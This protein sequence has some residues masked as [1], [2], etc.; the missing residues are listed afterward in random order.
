MANNR[1]QALRTSVS[2][3]LP[4]TTNPANSSYIGPG[5]FAVNL[6]DQKVV[7]S[8]GSL[9]FE[10][11]S[12]LSTL[13]VV[14]IAANGTTGGV[15]KALFSNATGGVYW[16]APSESAVVTVRE[17]FT[18]TGSC[19]T[20]TVTGGYTNNELDVFVN[21]VKFINGTEVDVSDGTTIVFTTA[22]FDTDVIEVVGS[23]GL[24]ILGVEAE[25]AGLDTYVQFN[26]GGTLMG[27]TSGFTF[28][29]GTNTVAIGNTLS[30]ASKFTA[31]GSVVNVGTLSLYANDGLGSAGQAL[32]S[33]GSA[34]YWDDVVAGAQPGGLDTYVQFN[35]GGSTLNGTAGFVFSKTTNNVT[36]TN[37]LFV[38][39]LIQIGTGTSTVNASNFSGTA[40]NTLFVGSTT[41]ENVVSNAQLSANLA[42]YATTG[43]L[44]AYQTEA[45]LAD[46]VATLAANNTAFVGSVS[47]ANVVSNAQLSANLGNYQTSAGMATNVAT[48]TANNT[49][50]VGSVS[51]ANVVSNA[52]LSANLANYATTT[53][54]DAYQTEAG[55]ADNVAT[56]SANNTAYV[57]SVTAANVVSNA[58][59]SANLGNYQTTA[60]LATNVATL[61]ANN[62]SFVGSVSAANVVSNAQLSANLGNY[63]TTAGL[64]TNVATLTANNTSF[65]GSESAANVVS[66]AQLS[67]NLAN[68]ATTTALD[69]YQTEAGLA[70]NVAT[71][72][73]NNTAFVG[74]VS[75]ANVVSNAQLSANL[76]NYQTTAGLATN[77]ATLTANNANNLGTVAAS[78]YVV[79]TDSRTLSGNL[80]F[81]GANVNFTGANVNFSGANANYSNLNVVSN[82]GVAAKLTVNSTIVDVGNLGFMAN[83]SV[84]SDGNVLKSNGSSAYWS[85]GGG[86]TPG[87]ANTYVQFND[88]TAFNGVAG[89][90]FDKATNNVVIANNLTVTTITANGS[91]G[92]TGKVM[93]S[94]STGGLFWQLIA[95]VRQQFSGTGACTTFTVTDGYSPN[96]LD[97][98]V[99]G[100]KY[101][102]GSDVDVSGGS[103]IIF[104]TAP[105]AGAT[106][107]VVGSK[108]TTAVGGQPGGVDTEVQFNDGG[109]Q[110]NASAGFT[111]NKTTNTVSIGNTL[112]IASV[113]TVNSTVI[114]TGALGLIANGEMG[115]AGKALLSNSIGGMY[116]G[117]AGAEAGGAATQ[118]QF[119]D[120][121]TPAVLNAT[122]GFTFTKGTN[123][124]FVAN[125]INVGTAT[126]NSTF[127]SQ[128]AN[129]ADYIGG[130][131]SANVV[132]N[133]QLS[134]NLGNYQTSAGMA[135]NVATLTA[136]ETSF[137]G[138]VSAANVVSN[139]QLSAN[140]GN[141]QTTTGLAANV[142]TLA[143]NS[144][145]YIGTL[146]A[147]NVVSNAQLSGN[148]AGYV[149]NDMNGDMTGNVRFTGANITFSGANLTFTGANAGF[150]NVVIVSNLGVA[151]K[152]TVNSTVVNVGNLG[153]I[154]NGTVGTDLQVLTSNGSAAYWGAA[155]AQGPAGPTGPKGTS[156]LAPLSSETYTLFWTNAAITLAEIRSVI[157]GSSTPWANVS[158][159]FGSDRTS[160]TTIQAAMNVSSTTTGNTQTSFACGAIAASSFVWMT[161]NTIGGTLNEFHAT[162]RF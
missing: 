42:G 1:Y 115:S 150:S 119:N 52:Q 106:I 158:F 62:T 152:L 144:A 36:I 34:T 142:Q 32:F 11:G 28:T 29:K 149:A 78:N 10:I 114:N 131:P 138:G 98:F 105:L 7:S 143:A 81:S 107:E 44:D 65:V 159:Y 101:V 33:N 75:A 53:S 92:T 70:D 128:T 91:L 122:A 8:D 12:N 126:I 61:T 93:F 104:S 127:F 68:Y 110:L 14:S 125:T 31:N 26:D 18:G 21:G 27:G 80:V 156:V 118:V 23:K 67:A 129:N 83:G 25:A 162:L 37:T 9:P 82:L 120:G 94:N 35:D 17:Q 24:T 73:A 99:N 116:W 157:V 160:A 38:A 153:I 4:N 51:A 108:T 140:L 46:N 148:L 109:T 63:Q 59:L 90:T 141:Y 136:N 30:V 112:V 89:F 137:V 22:P 147:A 100:V 49:S 2:G 84:G 88:S 54:L 154:A 39:N 15:G 71:L 133:A 86:G 64:A 121:G 19:T 41:A 102:N 95:A 161:F 13:T 79:N 139:A 96:E 48:L 40:N 55:L 97:V 87:G 124:I 135:T 146:I 145:N 74:A 123:N 132:S 155:G 45:G 3:R 134:A 16:D 130:L 72:T 117:T 6:T 50:F 66:N 60:G 58:Q 57:G 5:G 113:F 47:A 151:A 69:A 76:G 85:T 56:L 103:T 20:F 77:V 111:F 43:A